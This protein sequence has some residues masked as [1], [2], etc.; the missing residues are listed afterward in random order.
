M[1][2]LACIA[3]R[4]FS[5]TRWTLCSQLVRELRRAGR[6]EGT[7]YVARGV[8]KRLPGRITPAG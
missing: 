1:S 6:P 3:G 4:C 7:T 8:G 5:T 2:G